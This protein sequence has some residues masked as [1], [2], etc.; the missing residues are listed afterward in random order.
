MAVG[1]AGQGEASLDNTGLMVPGGDDDAGEIDDLDDSSHTSAH[2]GCTTTAVTSSRVDS[3]PAPAPA[4]V[5]TLATPQ[6]KKKAS[7]MLLALLFW[8]GMGTFARTEVFVLQTRYFTVCAGYGKVREPALPLPNCPTTS[9]T[10]Q[11]DS[12]WPGLSPLL[13]RG[14]GGRNT[15]QCPSFG[16]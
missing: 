9:P 6:K 16:V 8:C 15:V 5:V 4:A 1:V 2:T 14:G 3:A 10:H 7:W 11:F 12:L 13:I